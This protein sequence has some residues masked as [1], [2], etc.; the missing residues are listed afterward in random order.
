[1]ID[2]ISFFS[3]ISS[4]NF[5]DLPHFYL[6]GP[7]ILAFGRTKGFLFS[8]SSLLVVDGPPASPESEL[9]ERE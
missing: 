4:Y 2:S 7:M 8:L 6:N 1:M 5:N 9:R 3:Y